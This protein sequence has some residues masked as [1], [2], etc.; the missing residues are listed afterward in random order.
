MKTFYTMMEHL[1]NVHLIKDVGMIPYI[2]KQLGYYDA[3]IVSYGIAEREYSY[4]D[5]TLNFVERPKIFDNTLLDGCIWLTKNAKKIDVLNL[6]HYKQST[7]I[8]SVIYR[9]FNP[10]G[11]VYVKLDIDPSE[12]MKMKMKPRTLKYF[13]TKKILGSCKCISCETEC[14]QKYANSHWP[15]KLDYIPNGVC[16]KDI[17]ITAEKEKIILTVG[18]IGTEQKATEILLDAF[19]NAYDYIDSK[20]KLVL[21]GPA[22]EKFVNY[23]KKYKME[24]PKISAQIEYKGEI[25]ERDVLQ[26][27]YRRAAIFTMPSR[28][29]GF[30]LV[31]LEAIS[32][33]DFLLTTKL[34][35]FEEL[36]NYGQ[37]GEY[38]EIDDVEGYTS[39]MIKICKQF[40]KGGEFKRGELENYL[41]DKYCY[42]S[43]CSK[44]AKN[45]ED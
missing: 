17:E 20:W 30:C 40:E 5:G 4:L 43:I 19:K 37:F 13:L 42:E 21:V 38:F 8:W 32:K 18:R 45:L 6:Y 3:T 9:I 36:S 23:L 11:K 24:F 29:E 10:N 35:S 33:G 14:F 25:K 27:L 31:G 34:Y 15:V 16:K 44:L 12:G 22:E 7:F 2:L 1:E 41:I 39:K 28:W 26:N